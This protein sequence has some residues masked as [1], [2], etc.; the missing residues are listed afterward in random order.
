MTENRLFFC[1]LDQ[2]DELTI[3]IPLKNY[4]DNNRYRLV[5]A[6]ET[7]DLE[8]V[9]K[10]NLGVEVKLVCSFDAYITLNEIYQVVDADGIA[11]ELYT[12][13]IVRTDLFDN[14]Y[15]YKKND[16]GFTYTKESTKFKIWTP[17]AKKVTLELVDRQ[18]KTTF[19]DVPYR[20]LGVWRIVVDGDLDR[21]KYRI[22]SM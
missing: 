19:L 11:S 10:I 7:V 1:Y 9:E 13:K 15:A 20:N 12:G 17:V 5:G 18:G 4:R 14:I 8:I 2:F 6:G 3:I 21:W 16:L 22:S